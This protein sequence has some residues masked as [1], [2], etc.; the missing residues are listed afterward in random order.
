MDW[1][2]FSLSLKLA[3]WTC[4]LILPVA[5]LLA[6]ALAWGRFAG[7]SVVEAVVML[8]LVLPPTVLGF[9]LLSAFSPAS[10]FGAFLKW[11]FGVPLVFSFP[12]ILVASVII[13][14]P[15]AV[16]CGFAGGG[17]REIC[18]KEAIWQFSPLFFTGLHR[19]V[20]GIS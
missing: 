18:P 11:V 10:G 1:T 17:L 12:G 3:F 9:Y 15:F 8:P 6:R 2:A 13:N 4:V 7:K 14:L 20:A 19:H 16:G 5:I